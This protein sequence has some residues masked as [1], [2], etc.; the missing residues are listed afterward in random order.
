MVKAGPE[1]SLFKG[2]EYADA[3]RE[4]VESLVCRS[5]KLSNVKILEGVFPD[6]TGGLI[7]ATRFRFCHI[8]VDVYQS[9]RDVTEWI[10]DKL[11]VGGI[12]VYDDYGF[13]GCEGIVKCVD[14]QRRLSDR[15]VVE[16][17][18]GHAVVIKIK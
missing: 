14:E 16:N 9:A 5:L 12:L 2:G 4:T 15:C 18:N 1:D 3:T 13:Y 11:V 8:D 17:L 7:D 10:W 6:Q